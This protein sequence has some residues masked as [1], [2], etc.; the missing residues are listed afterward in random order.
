MNKRR[1]N[2]LKEGKVGWWVGEWADACGLCRAT[3]Y[4]LLAAGKLRSVKSGAA[5]IIM[6]AP[7]E[8]LESLL[9]D[10]V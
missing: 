9:K 10:A 7:T 3:V 5:R 2:R 1:R 6:T 8:Y 4:N